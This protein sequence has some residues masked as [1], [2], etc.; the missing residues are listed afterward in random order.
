M[1]AIRSYYALIGSEPGI[2][3]D[4]VLR[5]QLTLQVLQPLGLALLKSYERYDPLS[6]GDTRT[7]T[8]AEALAGVD[9]PSS[10][11]LAYFRKGVRRAAPGVPEFDLMFV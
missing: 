3:Q 10:E 1:Y 7:L 8:F 11:V 9:P 6:G 4:M 5:Q 2:V